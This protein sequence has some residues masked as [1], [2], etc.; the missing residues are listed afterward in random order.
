MPAAA[1]GAR[2]RRAQE[3]NCRGAAA[4]ATRSDS[5]SLADAEAR[6]RRRAALAIGRVGST[7]RRAGARAPRSATPTP[8]CARWRRSALG[9]I[10]D[11]TRA[12]RRCSTAL[13]PTP[14]PLV[15]GVAAEALGLIGEG[16]TQ[17]TATPAPRSAR[18]W[19]RRSASGALNAVLPDELGYPLAPPVEAFRLGL[20]ALARLQAYDPLAIAVLDG[21]GQPRCDGGRWPTRCGRIG[22][23]RALPALMLLARREDATTAA[24]AVRGTRRG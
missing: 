5:S 7:R 6:L 1:A 19:R 2:P 10:G 23:P 11:A 14:S 9:L 17:V 12:R 15:R 16:G 20:Y 22:D 21:S 13:E 4:A 24:F 18:W 3:A 8:K